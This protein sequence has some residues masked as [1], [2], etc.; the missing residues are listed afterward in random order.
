M[1]AGARTVVTAGW[2]KL[3]AWREPSS[4]LEIHCDFIGTWFCTQKYKKLT[5]STFKIYVPLCVLSFQKTSKKPIYFKTICFLASN[6][7]F[8]HSKE[9]LTLCYVNHCKYVYTKSSC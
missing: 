1:A 6:H 4:V 5:E 2:C 7:S 9:C 8:I 3:E